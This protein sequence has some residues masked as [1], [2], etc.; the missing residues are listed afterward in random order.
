M[1]AIIA[2]IMNVE[3]VTYARLYVNKTT[4]TDARGITGKTLAP[5]VVGGSDEDIA[6]VLRLKSGATDNFQGNL[7]TPI[8]YVGELGDV[9][10][11]DFYRPTEVPIY[12]AIEITVTNSAAYPEDAVDQIKQAIVDY[13]VY[14][15]AGM[16]GF[17]PGA[18]VLISRLYT[19]I[20]SVS[21]FKVD[22]L[23][24]GTDSSILSTADITIN[25]DE[26]ATFYKNN[27][28]ITVNT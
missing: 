25:W 19:P 9:Q 18:D 11:I 15:Q 3:G 10:T 21:G 22:S 16:A 4:T 1:D 27:I 14:D 24:I 26:V 2:G 23:E 13:A 20:N 28:S 5:V 8:Q 12:I 7:T 6:N 17:P